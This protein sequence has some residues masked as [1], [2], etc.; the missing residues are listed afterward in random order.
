MKEAK[1]VWGC[2]GGE[3]G[4][5]ARGGSGVSGWRRKLVEGWGVGREGCDIGRRGVGSNGVASSG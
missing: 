3:G 5:G 4:E 1:G 2:E